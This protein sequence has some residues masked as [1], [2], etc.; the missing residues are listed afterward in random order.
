M[1][2]IAL[3]YKQ[4]F[5]RYP[6]EDEEERWNGVALDFYLRT[7]D[8]PKEVLHYKALASAG[9]RSL[10]YREDQPRV[11][12]GNPDGG[13]WTADGGSSGENDGGGGSGNN[14]NGASDTGAKKLAQRYERGY[15][16]SERMTPDGRLCRYL[17]SFGIVEG[18]GS[19]SF[20]C[21]PQPL[22][23][24]VTH[25]QLLPLNDNNRSKAVHDDNAR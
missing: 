10:K 9:L 8:V 17:F 12:A 4:R 19:S 22:S 15:L 14:D 16:L 7:G 23:S 20:G 18:P 2:T 1:D 5:E 3:R 25:Y 11:P 24:A 6:D 21:D 13:Q